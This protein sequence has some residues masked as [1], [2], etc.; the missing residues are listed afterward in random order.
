MPL[1]EIYTEQGIIVFYKK[2]NTAVAG[3]DAASG[4]LAQFYKK[5]WNVFQGDFCCYQF[6]IVSML[7]AA[8]ENKPVFKKGRCKGSFVTGLNI[9]KE[10]EKFCNEKYRLLYEFDVYGVAVMYSDEKL[11]AWIRSNGFYADIQVGAVDESHIIA[12]GE[13]LGNITWK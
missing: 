11:I 13:H 12:L 4:C 3:Y 1:D 8:M 2:K 9:A 6:C 5:E 7:L 10:L